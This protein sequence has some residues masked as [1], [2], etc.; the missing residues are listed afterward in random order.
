M[1]CCSLPV[2]SLLIGLLWLITSALLMVPL[3]SILSQLQFEGFM[4][5]D[6]LIL[7]EQEI[8]SNIPKYNWTE[9][10]PMHNVLLSVPRYTP[11]TILG[12]TVYCALMVMESALLVAG[13]R[14]KTRLLLLPFIF[15]SFIDLFLFLNLGGFLCAAFFSLG[16]VPGIMATVALVISGSVFIYLWRVVVATYGDLDKMNDRGA[17]YQKDTFL[18]T[19]PQQFDALERDK[20]LQEKQ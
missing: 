8:Q 18:P 15:H 6:N 19:A 9:D 10:D 12:G 11:Y 4:F 7:F 16:L 13:V 1:C 17:E 2:A 3:T 20:M 5:Q 14:S